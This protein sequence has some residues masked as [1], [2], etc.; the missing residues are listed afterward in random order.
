LVNDT[1]GHAAGDALIVQISGLLRGRMR[2]ADL[3]ARLGG[4]EFGVLLIDCPL[5]EARLVGKQLLDVIRGFRF[6]WE[7]KVFRI[8]ASVGLAPISALN[9]D[10]AVVLSSADL[11]CHMAKEKGRN[12]IWVHDGDEE[13]PR[14]RGEMQW[15]HRIEKALSEERL[16]LYYQEIRATRRDRAV[17]SRVEV[18]VRMQGE[19]GELVP[20]MA[21]IPPAERYQVM[22]RIDRWVID[23]TFALIAAR[24]SAGRELPV[25]NIN[26]SGQS[27]GQDRFLEF[28]L[29][30][31]AHYGFPPELLCFE[32]T[33][34]VA[35]SNVVMARAFID[36]LVGRGCEFA[37]DDFGRGMSSFTYLKH[38]PVT[39]LK[40][41]GSFVKNIRSDAL[42]RAM[43]E[44][45]NHIGHLMGMETIAEF[46][47]DEATARLLEEIGVD[48]VQGFGIHRPAPLKGM[49]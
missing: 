46:V 40:I 8:G 13:L 49:P 2:D 32:I 22:G 47:A 39:L 29:G 30:R 15:I 12:R 6:A 20:P 24:W 5:P 34:T 48:W 36:E 44:S 38:L 9:R 33:E 37:L 45:V 3:L 42:D 35:V 31:L 25:F 21:F 11:A 4:D 17:R 7:D 23:R 10:A 28:V 43:V 18:L 19:D 41:D 26:I 14:R 27:L 1:C 16:R